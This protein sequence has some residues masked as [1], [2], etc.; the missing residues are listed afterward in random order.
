MPDIKEEKKTAKVPYRYVCNYC[1]KQNSGVL[2]I[3][4]VPGEGEDGRE[5][6]YE[7]INGKNRVISDYRTGL[8]EG[9]EFTYSAFS[10][11]VKGEHPDHLGMFGDAVC[12]ECGKKQ[13]WSVDHS[14]NTSKAGCIIPAAGVILGCG[15]L[16]AASALGTGTAAAILAGAGVALIVAGIILSTVISKKSLE[17]HLKQ[18]LQ[19]PNDPEK[20]PVLDFPDTGIPEE[21]VVAK[22]ATTI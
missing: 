19:E 10:G 16:G 14:A 21:E 1:G 9:R 20:L 4:Y 7:E 3:Q 17:K 8:R 5:G 6:L 12:A 2:G 22:F 15:F 18:L 13:V 11:R